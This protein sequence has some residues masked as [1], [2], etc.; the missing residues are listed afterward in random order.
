[1]HKYFYLS[2]DFSLMGLEMWFFESFNFHKEEELLLKIQYSPNTLMWSEVR[3]REKMNFWQI[4]EDY[5]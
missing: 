3:S 5:N 4:F 1:M 2:S